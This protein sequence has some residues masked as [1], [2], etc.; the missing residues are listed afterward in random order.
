MTRTPWHVRT[1]RRAGQPAVLYAALALSAPGEFSLGVTAG[2]DP[3]VAW[4]MPAVLSLWAAW[5]ARNAR[6]WAD[7]VQTHN[8][9]GDVD[10][11]KVAK[12]Q[13]GSAVRGAVLAL[14]VATAAQ[15]TEHVLT[16]GATGARAWVVIV[17][18]AVPPLVAAHVLHLD[19][20]GEDVEEQ[21]ATVLSESAAEPA[22]AFKAEVNKRQVTVRTARADKPMKP[23]PDAWLPI[24]DAA[25]LLGVHE[26]TLYRRRN[27]PKS[28]IRTREE[29]GRQ[30]V[31]WA[32]LDPALNAA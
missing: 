5:S 11:A 30:L 8:E 23:T 29:G 19:P 31:L 9:A 4:L 15:I 1:A 3:R 17:V 12:R 2:W 18:S 7:L 10:R 26:S 13:R 27:S 32:S 22:P 24:A 21:P 6:D 20:P 14:I 28:R 25:K 16:T